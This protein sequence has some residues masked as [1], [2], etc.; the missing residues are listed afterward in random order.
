MRAPMARSP[1]TKSP[2][3][4]SC[5]RGTPERRYSPP[6]KASAAVSGRNA[7]PAFPRKRSALRT[8]NAPP[9]PMTFSFS[10]AIPRRVSASRIT[11]VSSASS[12]PPISV[13]PLARAER[14]RTRFEMLFEPGNRTVPAA[15]RTGG[16][17]SESIGLRPASGPGL[18]QPVFARVARLG[19]QLFQR[20]G[21]ARG[22]KL[23]HRRQLLAE[24][25]DFGAE[26]VGIGEADV[27]P[28]LRMAGRNARE[29]AEAAGR[30]REKLRGVLAAR[31]VMHQSVGKE[32]RQVAHR[33]EHGIVL[34]GRHLAGAGAAGRPRLVHLLHR[35]FG[36]LRQRRDHDPL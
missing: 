27:A 18:A 13:A 26:A 12:K 2:I 3:G 33:G 22:E 35:L 31:Y 32:V 25:R 6:L 30:E 11:F 10:K 17:A 20:S 24:A 5:M 9:A 7:V 1:S 21:I 34:L 19:E 28:H 29:V 14:S 15:R 8:G 36:I 4:R 23:L 16:S